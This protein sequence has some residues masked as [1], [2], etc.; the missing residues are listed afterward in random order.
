M[1]EGRGIVDKIK[2]DGVAIAAVV[3]LMVKF[4]FVGAGPSTPDFV[5][6]TPKSS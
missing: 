4:G 5:K 3:L 6:P 2:E 1:A